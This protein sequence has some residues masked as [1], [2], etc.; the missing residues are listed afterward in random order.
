MPF[1]DKCVNN[2]HSIVVWNIGKWFLLLWKKEKTTNKN[3]F[4]KKKN[5]AQNHIYKWTTQKKRDTSNETKWMNEWMKCKR[6]KNEE[7]ICH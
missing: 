2:I 5:Y 7:F 4:V 6:E 1:W 3:R